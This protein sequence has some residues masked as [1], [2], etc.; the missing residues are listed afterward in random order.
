MSKD[1]CLKNDEI[2]MPEENRMAKLVWAMDR[3]SLFRHSDFVIPSKPGIRDFVILSE[4]PVTHSS[5]AL[6][7]WRDQWLLRPGVTYLNHGSFGPSPKPVIAARQ[8]WIERLE[9]DP[10][11]FFVRQM[12]GHLEDARARLGNL[13][14]TSGENLLFVDNAT[15]G[16][17]IVAASIPLAAGD[18]VLAT[19]HE[20][21]AV[22][23]IWRE[24]CQKAGARLVVQKLPA[25]FVDAEEVATALF[26]GASARTRLI[27]SWP[28]M[29][30]GS[31][32]GATNRLPRLRA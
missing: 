14:G 25:S 3:V 16:M 13:V 6:T 1:E 8:A 9:S 15:F 20:Y 22:L 28:A 4:D 19:N 24:R 30:S 7:P 5:S 17:N 11:D 32:S 10:M 29:Y 23:R 12:E 27:V 2:R 21:G 18:E 31:V 26:A